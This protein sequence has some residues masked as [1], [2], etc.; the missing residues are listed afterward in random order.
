MQGSI[1]KLN[2]THI[3]P[4]T[5]TLD[6]LSGPITCAGFDTATL[7]ILAPSQ[8]AVCIATYTFDQDSLEAGPRVFTANFSTGSELGAPLVPAA[9]TVTPQLAPA[10]TATIAESTCVKPA[11]AGAPETALEKLP[12]LLLVSCA[13]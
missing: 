12:F 13:I 2:V 6:Q 1:G 9:V 3:Q 7:P 10:M 11:K 5:A 4:T 8:S